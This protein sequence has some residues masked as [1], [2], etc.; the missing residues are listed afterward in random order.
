MS[1]RTATKRK[2]PE[3][4]LEDDGLVLKVANTG[5]DKP[6]VAAPA[7]ASASAPYV[8][9]EE[10]EESESESESEESGREDP[11]PAK[12]V[13]LAP[14][15]PHSVELLGALPADPNED[16]HG[17]RKLHG[18]Y[19]NIRLDFHDPL[20]KDKNDLK[21]TP[22][23]S[24]GK[25]TPFLCFDVVE[26]DAVAGAN[27][28]P[29][30]AIITGPMLNTTYYGPLHKL[31]DVANPVKS[32]PAH[33]H[34]SA[35]TMATAKQLEAMVASVRQTDAPCVGA[36]PDGSKSGFDCVTKEKFEHFK[37]WG[38][39]LAR[40]MLASLV[41]TDR[42]TFMKVSP[43]G[44]FAHAEAWW[45]SLTNEARTDLVDELRWAK[46]GVV[47]QYPGEDEPRRLRNCSLIIPDARQPMDGDK[48]I[49]DAPW[50]GGTGN[51]VFHAARR[52]TFPGSAGGATPARRGPPANTLGAYS[53]TEAD[54]KVLKKAEVDV[55]GRQILFK[56]AFAATEPETDKPVVKFRD[57]PAG[58]LGAIEGKTVAA[59]LQV[60]LS[61][62]PRPTGETNFKWLGIHPEA[63]QLVLMFGCMSEFSG[64][65][66]VD[67][68]HL[69]STD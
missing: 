36:N 4:P 58:D 27:G 2:L 6:E 17:V 49:K 69:G 51:G 24:K 1:K 8:A 19:E 20:D 50:I 44:K 55:A 26:Q 25:K 45:K 28:K 43:T 22:I 29:S 61:G 34:K 5:A 7:P 56:R 57:V 9:G 63:F 40:W 35:F 67:D 38:D 32:K 10:S 46:D 13:K 12:M 42:P 60:T 54:L 47:V 48:P 68:M 30:P 65:A 31:P 52:C 33:A 37:A 66:R 62:H 41:V 21:V 14:E 53:L 64:R 59:C 15:A 23:V 11:V 16:P 39:N 3:S 18:Y